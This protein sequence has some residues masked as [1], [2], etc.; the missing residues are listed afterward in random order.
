M[1]NYNKI[2]A[3]LRQIWA[4]LRSNGLALADFEDAI[5]EAVE[6]VKKKR[7]GLLIEIPCKVGDTVYVI[8][9]LTNFRLNYVNNYPQNNRVYKQIVHSV[10]SWNKDKYCVWTCDGINLLLPQLFNETWF[11]T[12]KEA[13]AKLKELKENG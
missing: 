9:S 1:M 10:Q 5:N 6:L 4:H 11:L 7:D 8:P 13:E 12:E 3:N 2:I